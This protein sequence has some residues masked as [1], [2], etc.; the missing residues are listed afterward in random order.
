MFFVFVC[1]FQLDKPGLVVQAFKDE[2]PTSLLAYTLPKSP[3]K[4]VTFSTHGE[5][6]VKKHEQPPNNQNPTDPVHLS[7]VCFHNFANK[8]LTIY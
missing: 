6:L 7:S 5:S 1:L 3:S 8:Y 4:K 2:P